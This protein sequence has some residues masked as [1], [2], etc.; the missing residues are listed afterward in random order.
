MGHQKR[1]TVSWYTPYNGLDNIQKNPNSLEQA[2]RKYN[3]IVVDKKDLE[4]TR[5][6]LGRTAPYQIEWPSLASPAFPTYYATT[7]FA[8]APAFS[9]AR[10]RLPLGGLCFVY[11]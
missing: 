5:L 3:Y 2:F 1:D 7:F 8:S 11:L 9:V 4:V 6:R 10:K